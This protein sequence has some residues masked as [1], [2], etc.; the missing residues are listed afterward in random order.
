MD[1]SDRITLFANAIS[2]GINHIAYIGSLRAEPHVAS[3][4]ELSAWRKALDD[5]Q[6]SLKAVRDGH[7]E[8]HALVTSRPVSDDLLRCIEKLC[9][10]IA[11]ITPGE[12]L[13]A[14]LFDGIDLAWV[15]LVGNA[16]PLGVMPPAGEPVSMSV[17]AMSVE[18]MSVE[19]WGAM[20][21]D[22]PG[23]L[24]GGHL[25][26]EETVNDEHE[27]IIS[28]LSA[29]L[30]RWAEPQGGFVA[31]GEVR[32]AIRE[33]QGRR[34]DLSVVLPGGALPVA[35]GIRR[36]APDI[37]IEVLVPTSLD[38]RRD[39]I[40]KAHDYAS[41]GVRWYWLLDP[42]T[43]TL[44]ILELG[45]DRRYI[46]TLVAAGGSVAIPGCAGLTLDLD[47]LWAEVERLWPVSS[48]ETRR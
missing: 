25:V 21:D 30:R 15:E 1:A 38:V 33:D 28:F 48:D 45:V 14:A 3:T 22:A 47:A 29:A 43:R 46:Y 13:S 10:Q 35:R 9:A 24:E 39:R 37:V 20:P 26:A 27:V 6:S 18:A 17:E 31:G 12:H 23:E 16:A 44:E 7:I 11:A 19:A 32:F 2:E 36:I 41:F 4:E 34:S 42:M 5:L 8:G 40:K